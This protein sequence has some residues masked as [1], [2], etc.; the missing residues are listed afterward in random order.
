MTVVQVEIGLPQLLANSIAVKGSELFNTLVHKGG[1]HSGFPYPFLVLIPE[2]NVRSC[3]L[4]VK[5]QRLQAQTPPPVAT[6][7]EN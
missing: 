5:Q 2:G 4:R 3:W 1:L 6:K 7:G